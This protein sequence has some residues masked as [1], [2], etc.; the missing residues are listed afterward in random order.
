MLKYDKHFKLNS[1][2]NEGPIWLVNDNE[3]L[4]IDNE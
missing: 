4:H 2:H 1:E 3:N